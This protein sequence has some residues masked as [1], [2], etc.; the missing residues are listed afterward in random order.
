MFFTM[1][2]VACQ[3][4]RHEQPKKPFVIVDKVIEHE[5]I[6]SLSATDGTCFY[7]Y[8]SADGQ[9]IE[10]VDNFDKYDVGDVIE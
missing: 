7:V 5:S 2:V 4:M 8:I 9:R 6:G 10:F 3:P 1:T